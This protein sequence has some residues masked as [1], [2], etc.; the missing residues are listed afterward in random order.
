MYKLTVICLGLIVGGCATNQLAESNNKIQELERRIA[1]IEG[2]LY[3][4]DVKSAPKQVVERTLNPAK[5]VER[6]VVDAK[7][8]AFIKEYIGVQF[9]DSIEK[10][11]QLIEGY[12][13]YMSNIVRR[14]TVL[15]KFK[16]FDKAE[17]YFEDGKLY[18][19]RFFADFDKKYSIDSIDEKANQ[20]IVDMAVTLGLP[21]TVFDKP[22]FAP[23]SRHGENKH[24]SYML[25]KVKDDRRYG[26]EIK[27]VNLWR[28]YRD[29]KHARVRATGET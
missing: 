10:Y 9:G 20:A 5:E 29:E 15:K 22:L 18:D 27:D 12:T 17:G 3:K 23:H 13:G 16:Y 7:I 14:I 26:V 19:I 8:N 25:G 1:R 11:P 2:D 6:N 24:S 28:K 4:I 21:N